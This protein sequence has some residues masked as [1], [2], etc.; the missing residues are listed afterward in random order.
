MSVLILQ[1]PSSGMINGNTDP[2]IGG[3][4]TPKSHFQATQEAAA[5]DDDPES[6]SQI[7]S[8]PEHPAETENGDS[9]RPGTDPDL[10]GVA[11]QILDD[12]SLKSRYVRA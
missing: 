12:S 9:S 7:R 1:Q 3:A 6:S 8:N 2:N 10:S 5:P 4:Q 11:Q